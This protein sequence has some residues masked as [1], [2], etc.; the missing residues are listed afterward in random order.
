M[1]PKPSRLKSLASELSPEHLVDLVLTVGYYN[2]V[3]RV[4]QTL[5]IDV[6][7]DYLEYLVEFPLPE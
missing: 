2:L 4:L 5:Q 3:V 1:L 7:P 6:E